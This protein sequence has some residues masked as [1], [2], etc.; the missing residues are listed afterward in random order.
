MK[1]LPV[2]TSATLLVLTLPSQGRAQPEPP[3]T[4]SW[5]EFGSELVD[6]VRSRLDELVVVDPV[7]EAG[8]AAT[9]GEV[10]R[11]LVS[12]AAEARA[13]AAAPG[14]EFEVIV[15]V[16]TEPVRADVNQFSHY[17]ISEFENGRL[18]RN[19]IDSVP[20]TIAD[21]EALEIEMR[22]RLSEDRSAQ[23]KA[24][25]RAWTALADQLSPQLAAKLGGS[26]VAR[27]TRRL[28]VT[29]KQLEAL[30]RD[31][32]D[33]IA[34]IGLPSKQV[35]LLE[36]SMTSLGLTAGGTSGYTGSGVSIWQTES[37]P[38]DQSSPA[39]EPLRF[40]MED[41]DGLPVGGHATRMTGLLMTVANGSTVHWATLEDCARNN[42]RSF[43]SDLYVSS[44]SA[45]VFED[46]DEED[47]GDYNRCAR[48]WDDFVLDERILPFNGAGNDNFP[49]SVGSASARNV[50]T[51]GA[52]DTTTNPDTVASFSTSADPNSGAFKPEIV[53]PGVDVSNAPF[54][55]FSGTSDATAIAAGL[56][57]VVLEAYPSLKMHPQVAKALIMASAQDV[58]SDEFPPFDIVGDADGAGMPN[59]QN[60]DDVTAWT[61]WLEGPNGGSS[62]MTFYVPL[63]AGKTYRIVLSWLNSG[64]WAFDH[65][66]QVSSRW[67]LSVNPPGTTHPTLVTAK[68]NQGFQM[69]VYTAPITG[70][71]AI[72]TTRL[73]NYDSSAPNAWG[74]AIVEH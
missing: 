33:L 45:L 57:A 46:V 3:D 12:P 21:Y 61:A 73:N 48:A 37:N 17:G 27:K 39:I 40:V 56:G 53:T 24:D 25:Q 9:E 67:Q 30:E 49:L 51:V 50:V 52:A 60:I 58:E 63:Q 31:G 65:N 11:P 13:D 35:S 23:A 10:G 26:T 74:I 41:D 7:E 15:S 20:A 36:D 72:N 43:S 4:E 18:V 6:H 19:S 1:P 68:F 62:G 69:M 16:R 44:L 14:E 22:A 38:P 8:D 34:A 47:L 28:T 54:F 64:Q 42:V 55:F 2:L 32:N 70:T 66:G 5:L 29:K 71:Y 59:F